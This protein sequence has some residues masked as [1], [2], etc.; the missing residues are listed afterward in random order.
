MDSL[1]INGFC[2]P[3]SPVDSYSARRDEKDGSVVVLYDDK[4]CH[5][6]EMI[7]VFK[8]DGS[9]TAQSCAWGTK[10]ERPVGTFSDLMLKLPQTGELNSKIAQDMVNAYRQT[11]EQNKKS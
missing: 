1:K 3:N 2:Y 11:N 4:K 8:Q 7:Y 5:D 10:S 9:A 6:E